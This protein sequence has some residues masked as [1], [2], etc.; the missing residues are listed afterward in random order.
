MEIKKMLQEIDSCKKELD[1]I[2]PF[3]SKQVEEAE[4]F[5]RLD[6][7]WSSNAIENNSISRDEVDVILGEGMTV[8]NHSLRELFEIIGGNYA[9]SFIASLVKEGRSIEES[10]IIKM[11]KLF[12]WN[13]PQILPGKYRDC[14]VYIDM[15]DGTEHT[16]PSP[17]KVPGLMKG[18]MKWYAENKTKLHPV[19]LA[20]DFHAKF[21]S[22]HPFRDGNGR[23]ARLLASTV[24]MQNGLLPLSIPPMRKIDYNRGLKSYQKYDNAE[25]FRAFI[26]EMT[27]MSMRDYSRLMEPLSMSK[28]KE[29]INSER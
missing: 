5:F 24:L 28:K 10:D 8:G 9:H 17:E 27:L 16:F 29:S 4:D 7:I 26:A 1:A 14:P 22:I 19:I 6:A 12:A 25:P 11:H 21:V 13:I 20:A 15:S 2:R 3:N 23:V 18:L